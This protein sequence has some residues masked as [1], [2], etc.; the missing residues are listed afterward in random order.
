[1]APVDT[2]SAGDFS[3]SAALRSARERQVPG[4]SAAWLECN[5]DE[6]FLRVKAVVCPLARRFGHDPA[7]AEDLVQEVFLKVLLRMAGFRGESTLETWIYRIAL[8]EA[9]DARRWHRRHCGREVRVGGAR[10]AEPYQRG[11]IADRSPS[12]FE[13]AALREL[14][15]RLAVAMAKLDPH[16][17]QALILRV[18]AGLPYSSIAAI[19]RV[20]VST[21]KHRVFRARRQLRAVLYQSTMAPAR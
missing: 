17:R 4:G 14:Q 8:N 21:A 11:A 12:P 10:D 16:C 5:Y 13:Q 1:M 9:H 7:A 20:S 2:R 18:T 6:L 15:S 3:C 19:L